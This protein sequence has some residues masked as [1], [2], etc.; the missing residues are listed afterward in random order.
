[1]PVLQAGYLRFEFQFQY[2]FT[3]DFGSVS[4]FVDTVREGGDLQVDAEGQQVAG[5]EA[6]RRPHVEFPRTGGRGNAVKCKLT[7]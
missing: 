2:N 6:S 5:S 1:M 3:S 4:F 7:W